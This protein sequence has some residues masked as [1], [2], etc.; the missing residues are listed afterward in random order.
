M[1]DELAI[2]L[3]IVALLLVCALAGAAAALHGEVLTLRRKLMKAWRA[4]ANLRRA[5]ETEQAA[6]RLDAEAHERRIRRWCSYA[7]EL[8]DV[9]VALGT[10]APWKAEADRRGVPFVDSDA[11]SL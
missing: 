5:L 6:R 10:L 1:A 2:A 9:C 11:G 4:Q 3:G 7:T 8:Q